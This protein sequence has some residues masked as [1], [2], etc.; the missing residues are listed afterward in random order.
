MSLSKLQQEFNECQG[1]LVSYA[2]MKGY[3]L[4]RGDG[5]RDPRVHG[6]FGEKKGYGSKWSC[7]K[8]RLAQDHNL[9]ID[10]DGDGKPDYIT[11]GDHP[12]YKD[13]GEFWE[14]LHP[15]ARWGGWFDDANHFSFEY[16]G[17]S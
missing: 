14:N 10:M 2:M 16:K 6:E 4:T 12:A 5:Y 7:H 9:F 15:L 3:K 17:K 1:V 13:L 11:D 8:K